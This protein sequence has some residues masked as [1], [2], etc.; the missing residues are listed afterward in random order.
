MS[1]GAGSGSGGGGP[2]PRGEHRV[3]DALRS[4]VER[5]R[6]ATAGP[7]VATRERAS[8]LL[9]DVVRRGREA[10]DELARRGQEAGAGLARR[11]P[12]R[13]DE[14]LRRLDRVEA[15]LAAIEELLRRGDAPAAPAAKDNPE[16]EG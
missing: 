15:R 13:R 4:A 14:V 3:A 5:T 12:G 8:G 6:A 9:D 1:E 11:G 10:G 2:A 16:V 7:A